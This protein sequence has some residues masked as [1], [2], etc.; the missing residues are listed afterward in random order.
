MEWNIGMF[1][2]FGV[3]GILM[4]IIGFA[5]LDCRPIKAVILNPA[6]FQERIDM[7]GNVLKWGQTNSNEYLLIIFA[8]IC[9]HA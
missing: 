4:A 9:T 2:I 3:F 1:G 8:L 6:G 5:F 7:L